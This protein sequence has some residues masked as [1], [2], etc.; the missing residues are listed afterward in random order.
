MLDPRSVRYAFGR[1][2]GASLSFA[3]GACGT[4][5]TNNT[6]NVAA[7]DSCASFTCDEPP[8]PPA[9]VFDWRDAV[10]YFA[11]VDRFVDG[12]P[13]NNCNVLGTDAAG[14]FKGGD[15]AGLTSKIT[16]GY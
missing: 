13:A 15:W 2:A 7:A 8:V 10:I 14:N 11:F 4:D 1:V 6:N 5:A 3:L 16:G 9:G 12:N